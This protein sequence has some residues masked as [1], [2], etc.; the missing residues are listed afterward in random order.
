MDL[1]II[2][3]NLS[4]IFATLVALITAKCMIP[5]AVQV[6][7]SGTGWTIPTGKISLGVVLFACLDILGS[8]TNWQCTVW[9]QPTGKARRSIQASAND[10][11]HQILIGKTVETKIEEPMCYT[12]SQ[13][14]QVANNE[15]MVARLQRSRVKFNKIAH[16]QDEEGDTIRIPHPYTGDAMTIFVTNLT[17]RIK[18]PTTGNTDGYMLDDIEGWVL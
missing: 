18:K 3:P 7:P 17:R 5:D 14:Q 9:A 2:A 8:V 1:K 4:G 13:C 11:D 16:L 15:L 6:G 12:V 10:T